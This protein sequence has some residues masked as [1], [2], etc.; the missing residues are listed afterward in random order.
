MISLQPIRTSR[1]CFRMNSFV[2]C[3]HLY[4]LFVSSHIQVCN[5][6]AEARRDAA[7]VALM[8]S[9]THELPC[10]RISSQFIAESLQQAATD[11]GVCVN[12]H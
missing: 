4:S 6:Q 8:N 10:R 2:P 12:L 5:T 11:S 7:R 1:D 3:L 9:L